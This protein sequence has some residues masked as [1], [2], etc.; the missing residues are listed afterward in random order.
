MG[1]KRRQW[2]AHA[3]T[4][5]DGKTRGAGKGHVLS[6]DRFFYLA[7]RAGEVAGA[8]GMRNQAAS[9][10]SDPSEP[11]ARTFKI[12]REP[13]GSLQQSK[14]LSQHRATAPSLYSDGLG[15][16]AR[17][18]TGFG[19]D[20]LSDFLVSKAIVHCLREP[21]SVVLFSVFS[22]SVPP[23]SRPFTE[24]CLGASS[25]AAVLRFFMFL[26]RFFCAPLCRG[27]RFLSGL[28]RRPGAGP[29]RAGRKLLRGAQAAQGNRRG[30]QSAP[31]PA[32]LAAVFLYSASS[33]SGAAGVRPSSA[34]RH[35][36]RGTRPRKPE[37]AGSKSSG[38]V[39]I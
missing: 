28:S 38:Y 14:I 25:D 8:S 2:G 21:R 26:L 39:S 9:D 27:S 17:E 18:A 7:A 24:P 10:H 16:G 35:R 11:S 3:E 32:S 33:A 36:W 1:F 22:I 15:R 37:D 4:A 13:M 19:A 30:P 20:D 23:C 5:Y 31:S 6:L 29:L 34:R 12:D